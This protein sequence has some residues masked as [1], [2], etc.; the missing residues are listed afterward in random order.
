M[1]KQE[2]RLK[3]GY[4]CIKALYQLH[5][6]DS[7]MD[8][9]VNENFIADRFIYLDTNSGMFYHNHYSYNAIINTFYNK[10]N[11]TKKKNEFDHS[12]KTKVLTRKVWKLFENGPSF[13]DFKS[14]LEKEVKV[15]LITKEENKNREAR[16]IEDPVD[17]YKHTGISHIYK[18]RVGNFR[19]KR[20]DSIEDL[21]TYFEKIKVEEFFK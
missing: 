21:M 13:E 7:W 4:D 5:K 20:I 12:E 10:K 8:E 3:N 14:F 19:W 16:D 18:K 1:S 2:I 11:G 17:R 15:V 9:K 6:D